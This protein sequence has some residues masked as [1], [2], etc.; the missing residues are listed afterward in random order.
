MHLKNFLPKICS[1]YFKVINREYKINKATIALAIQ[2]LNKLVQNSIE[3]PAKPHKKENFLEKYK[4]I[5]I[6]KS[7]NLENPEEVTTRLSEFFMTI[8][9]NIEKNNYNEKVA[10]NFKIL[11][12]ETF[13]IFKSTPVFKW[14]LL[15]FL[16][17]D[18]I[19][20]EYQEN[21]FQKLVKKLESCSQD[22]IE[23]IFLILKENLMKDLK[24]LE[25]IHLNLDSNLFLKTF[26]MIKSSFSLCNIAFKRENNNGEKFSNVFN[27]IESELISKIFIKV[28]FVK[29]L[30]LKKIEVLDPLEFSLFKKDTID[31]NF[32]SECED[33]V[34]NFQMRKIIDNFEI[35]NFDEKVFFSVNEMFV[36]CE[37]SLNYY[38]FDCY[39]E[40]LTELFFIFENQSKIREIISLLYLLNQLVGR[41]INFSIYNRKWADFLLKSHEVTDKTKVFLIKYL[42]AL[43]K[44]DYFPTE[45]I[46]DQI[47]EYKIIF[48][49]LK[50]EA[51]SK[52]FAILPCDYQS[53][54]LH[55]FN[56]VYFLLEKY[57]ENDSFIRSLIEK[58]LAYFMVYV[59]K[60]NNVSKFLDKYISNVIN[61]V[62]LQIRSIHMLENKLQPFKV[63][64]SL[65]LLI[66]KDDQGISMFH[67]FC[68][69]VWAVL[70]KFY[71]R[72]YIL[73]EVKFLYLILM[74]IKQIVSIL[75]KKPEI[76]N[77]N[78]EEN[79]KF[80]EIN[81]IRQILMRIKPLTVSRNKEI[82][83]LANQIFKESLYIINS[84]SYISFLFKSYNR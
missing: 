50:I 35:F 83:V 68:M 13:E 1:E 56:V 12:L 9:M 37:F 53:N 22:V 5:M 16:Y 2:G 84:I 71:D 29:I 21:E 28:F 32:I 62:I 23:Q 52:I 44:F 41:M 77:K 67:L 39:F 19:F 38:L 65:L 20:L 33:K 15:S 78:E 82:F 72:Y 75:S 79:M 59:E 30:N 76:V 6:K 60:Q 57:V 48:E 40:K 31:I 7:E 55:K 18:N 51:I 36:N 42:E 74:V 70:I 61:R 26:R 69:D 80:N 64:Q 25:K 17:F 11:V 43:L 54:F 81:L 66:E 4:N 63:F 46:R 73:S 24:K 10:Q 47:N 27:L 58:N 34:F 8:Y 14:L 49:M 45:D 3:I